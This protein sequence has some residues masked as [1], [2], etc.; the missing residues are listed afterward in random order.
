MVLSTPPSA[1]FPERLR[2]AREYRGLNQAELAQKAE[3]LP[4]VE[5]TAENANLFL[6]SLLH[7]TVEQ[8]K[9]DQNF[10]LA[11]TAKPRRSAQHY[12]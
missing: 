3:I 4:D 8:P 11:Q 2:S 12:F 6:T 7:S 5:L 1:V 9:A 10:R